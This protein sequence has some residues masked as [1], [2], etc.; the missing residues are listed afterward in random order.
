[1]PAWGGGGNK[2]GVK[3]VLI[4]RKTMLHLTFMGGSEVRLKEADNIVVT[5]WGGTEIKMPT[6][7]EKMIFIR[8]AKKD[9][10]EF[11]DCARR[12][13]AITLMGG[14]AF[15]TPTLAQE[16][17][18]MSQ[19]R[20]SGLVDESEMRELWQLAIQLPTF[21][22]IETFTIMGGA[23]EEKPSRKDELRSLDSL[24]IKGIISAPDAEDLRQLIEGKSDA[25]R[26]TAIQEKIRNLLFPPARR[27]LVALPSMK[28]SVATHTE[29]E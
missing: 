28:R 7:A 4:T 29:R 22:L 5:F 12:T 23:G 13:N 9:D 6:L 2:W 8:Q 20:D 14:V 27:T 19:L 15:R 11:T 1:M 18:E 25:S 26:T 24:V 16:I 10:R 3:S 17:E 21:D